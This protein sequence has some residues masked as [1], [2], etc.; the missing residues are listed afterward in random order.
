MSIRKNLLMLLLSSSL[1]VGTGAALAGPSLE[2]VN[3]DSDA[4]TL[5]ASGEVL[6]AQ[7]QGKRGNRAKGKKRG[8][9]AQ[10]KNAKQARKGARKQTRKKLKKNKD[11]FKGKDKQTVKALARTH[12][13]IK[14]ARLG[15]KKNGQGKESF[16][17]AAIAQ[18]AA[19]HALKKN[20]ETL[21]LFLTRMARQHAK[22]AIKAN[23]GKMSKRIA[24]QPGEFD[25]ADGRGAKQFLD[26]AKKMSK[27]GKGKSKKGKRMFAKTALLLKIAA[28]ASK[29]NETGEDELR[30]AAVHMR[31]ARVAA[32][33]G[34]KDE[35]KALVK[36]ARQIAREI[37]K[38]TRTAEP[39]VT[40]DEA[41]EFAGASVNASETAEYV[42]LADAE[43]AIEVDETTVA[44]WD[45]EEEAETEETPDF[46][47]FDYELADE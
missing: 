29:K 12:V 30:Q 11:R 45:E 34:D 42:E 14:V 8:K 41:G 47:E 16:A 15:V 18:R 26:M 38:S 13:A 40:Q 33:E 37:L 9:R 1:S 43:V 6:I 31:A 19:G 35:A 46:E 4:A 24:D 22:A 25:K 5:S 44:E 20:K 32:K 21:A 2:A 23:R 7:R 36:K 10:P 17:K 39:T 28:K 3:I 27:R